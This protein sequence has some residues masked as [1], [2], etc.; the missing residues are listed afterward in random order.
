MD[1]WIFRMCLMSW[2]LVAFSVS[3][4]IASV[5]L[6]GGGARPS[7]ALK[8]FVK[9][10]EG[11]ILVMTWPTSQPEA[12]FEALSSDLIAAGAVGRI[13][14]AIRPQNSDQAK[15]FR[16][17]L[18]SASAVFISGGD[19]NAALDI[20]ERFQLFDEFKDA[21]SRGVVFAGTSAGT[22]MM[23]EH[24]MTGE[25]DLTKIAKGNT[26]FRRGLGLVPFLVDQHFLVRG[27]QNRLMSG[28]M[29]HPNLQGVGVDEDNAA[30]FSM[31]TLR[32]FG[33]SPLLQY[34]YDSAV[35]TFEMR[36][37]WP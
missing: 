19:Q 34:T 16:Q 18:K 37:I 36:I 35:S 27:R 8:L 11:V 1:A 22:A 29:D 30:V 15:E 7:S 28:L 23:S 6:F 10:S 12:S 17:Q 3:Q 4:A 5:F 14:H 9:E 20:V 24:A 21:Q 33:Q 26:Q 25:A 32:A 2:L 31:S 13:H